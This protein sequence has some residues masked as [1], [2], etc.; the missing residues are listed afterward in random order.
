MKTLSSF[1][2]NPTVMVEGQL[3]KAL[4]R[5]GIYGLIAAAIIAL[6][7]SAPDLIK[8]IVEAIS[9]KGGPLNQDFHR[10]FDEESQRG[11]TREIQYRYA[12]GLDVII[13]NQER[14]YILSDPNFVTSNL[15]D[16]DTTRTARLTTQDIQYGYVNTL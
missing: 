13:T 1:A 12:V 6:V 9:V 4:A 7:L 8:V 2:K 3:M 15:V 16:I 5:A 10:F 14:K 11:L